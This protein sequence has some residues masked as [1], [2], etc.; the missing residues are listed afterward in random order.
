M[1]IFENTSVDFVAKRKYAFI[2]SSVIILLGLLSFATRGVETGID[3]LGGTELVVGTEAPIPVAE[4][5]GALEGPLGGAPEVKLYGADNQYLIRTVAEGDP[6][7]LQRTVVGTFEEAFEGA[8]P[9]ILSMES[10]GPRF[11]EDLKRGAIWSVLAALFVIFAYIA[12]RFE[13]RYSVGAVA[14]LVHDVL[15]T[16]GLFSL[17]QGI[18]PFS[19]Q[20]D[21]T[22]I[23]AF[24][25]IVGYSIND[26]VVVFDRIREYANLFQTE[27]FDRVA[28]RAINTTLS[29]TVLTSGT[30]LLVVLMLF[31]FGG[32]VLKGF[33]FALLVGVGI[34]TYSSIFIATPVVLALRDRA[35]L[36]LAGAR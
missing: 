22:I 29:R 23:A 21:Q 11:A 1:R 6:E 8:T 4:V 14:C 9:T 12:V 5:S 31:L 36:T 26:T 17:L 19:L 15:F 13:W 33:T 30:T 7:V 2:I 3:F 35:G 10:V 27:R 24:L 18:V 28:N 25:T 34:G 32:E 20:V 16:L